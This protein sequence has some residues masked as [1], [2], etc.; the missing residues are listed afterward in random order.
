MNLSQ[1]HYSAK[2]KEPVLS[3]NV[4]PCLHFGHSL[5]GFLG[6]KTRAGVEKEKLV[7]I[8]NLGYIL[9]DSYILKPEHLMP[10]Q[11]VF[12]SHGMYKLGA[13]GFG[14]V[15]WWWGDLFL[16]FFFFIVLLLFSH[17]IYFFH[18]L[19]YLFIFN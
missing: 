12:V 3:L 16:Y 2:N 6:C 18:N 11:N 8:V 4:F 9:H 14:I 7:I 5:L 1:C 15:W 17:F 13:C 10:M 19:A